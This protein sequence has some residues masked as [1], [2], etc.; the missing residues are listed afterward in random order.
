MSHS[1]LLEH[2]GVVSPGQVATHCQWGAGDFCDIFTFA[3]FQFALVYFW[4]SLI[5]QLVKNLPAMQETW[6]QSLGW[7]RSPG[8]GKGSALQYSG[9]WTHI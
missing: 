1:R 6:V 7:G 4:A 8:E 3:H 9:P 2:Q 5:A